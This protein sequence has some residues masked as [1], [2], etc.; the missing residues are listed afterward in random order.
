MIEEDDAEYVEQFHEITKGLSCACIIL[1]SD[2]VVQ[3]SN[4]KAYDLIGIREDFAQ[5]K[6]LMEAIEKDGL[7]DCLG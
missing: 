4:E 5:D 7:A 3:H 1:N 2:K 6:D